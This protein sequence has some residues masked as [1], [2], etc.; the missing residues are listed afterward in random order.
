MGCTGGLV[1]ETTNYRPISG[2]QIAAD[3]PPALSVWERSQGQRRG[4]THDDTG[5]HVLRCALFSFIGFRSVAVPGTATKSGG[6]S[7]A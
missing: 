5:E 6:E 3:L 4:V 2:R 1:G 7:N